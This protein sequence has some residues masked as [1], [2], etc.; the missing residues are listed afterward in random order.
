MQIF[1][2][3]EKAKR[4]EKK[5]TEKKEKENKINIDFSF[6]LNKRGG[7]KQISMAG[8]GKERCLT[9]KAQEDHIKLQ[10]FLY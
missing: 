1:P 4:K 10:N 7:K 6:L 9:G 5:R 2:W 3:K 8:E